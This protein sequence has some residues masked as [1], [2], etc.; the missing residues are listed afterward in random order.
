M[1]PGPSARQMTYAL[2][3]LR[4]KSFI[5]R[6]PRS[7]RYELT[8]QGRRLAVL[9]HQDASPRRTPGIL[10]PTLAE[11]DSALPAEISWPP[12]SCMPGASSNSRS[13]PAF[14]DA[15]ITA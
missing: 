4:R 6:V 10:G 15:A 7:Q 3:R 14:I 2:H 12:G 13:T 11:L 1:L 8:A 9:P 5:V